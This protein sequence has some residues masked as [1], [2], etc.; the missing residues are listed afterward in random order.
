M[1]SANESLKDM[2]R[3]AIAATGVQRVELFTA[4]LLQFRGY[5]DA[6][7]RSHMPPTAVLPT[8]RLPKWASALYSLPVPETTERIVLFEYDGIPVGGVPYVAFSRQMDVREVLW[9]NY[10]TWVRDTG[11]LS[12]TKGYVSQQGTGAALAVPG[13]S[14][15]VAIGTELPGPVSDSDTATAKDEKLDMLEELLSLTEWLPQVASKETVAA[16]KRISARVA[17]LRNNNQE[18]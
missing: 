11:Y 15:Y 2:L 4:F 14:V 7:F 8:I 17:D 9:Q 10:R 3:D 6:K 12:L 1:G 13:S 5:F 18:V 16:W